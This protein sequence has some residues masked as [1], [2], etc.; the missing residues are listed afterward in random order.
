MAKYRVLCNAVILALT[1]AGLVF[2][3]GKSQPQAAQS[4]EAKRFLGT[5]RLVSIVSDGQMYPAYGDHPVGLIYYDST[6]H[7][8]VQVMPDRTRPKF[9]GRAPT[10]DEAQ[11]AL[12]GYVAYFGTFTVNESARTVTHHR[13]GS[14]TPGMVGVDLVRRYEFDQKDRLILT[15]VEAPAVHLTWE[16]LR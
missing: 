3:H 6:G 14:L 7:M 15:P 11:S 1:I 5:W 8:A 9:A 12:V 13:A 10:P 2:G 4:S 16:R